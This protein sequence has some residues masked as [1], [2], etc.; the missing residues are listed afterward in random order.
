MM[1]RNPSERLMDLDFGHPVA[2]LTLPPD[3][4]SLAQLVS[5]LRAPWFAVTYNDSGC[6][7]LAIVFRSSRI[8]S[9]D[10]WEQVT[11]RFRAC[12]NGAEL[13]RLSCRV[14]VRERD[15][16]RHIAIEPQTPRELRY[17]FHVYISEQLTPSERVLNFLL[18]SFRRF[19]H[20]PL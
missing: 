9:C 8:N 14:T 13:A 11:G 1:W 7:E 18:R 4:S 12:S 16:L 2:S 20:R 17:T 3:A 5:A 10:V 15:E 19:R 6:P